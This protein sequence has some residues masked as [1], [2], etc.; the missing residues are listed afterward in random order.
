[1]SD[2]IG[3]LGVDPAPTE[4]KLLAAWFRDP[5]LRSILEPSHRRPYDRLRPGPPESV[6]ER[7]RPRSGSSDRG[8]AGERGRDGR[9]APRRL[10]RGLR[11]GG[12]L[13]DAAV[14]LALRRTRS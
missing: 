9:P 10:R 11:L 7:D 3:F 14:S 13:V 6:I 12:R 5:D 8:A 1:M 2:G 4:V